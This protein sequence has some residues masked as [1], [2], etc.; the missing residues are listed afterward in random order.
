MSLTYKLVPVQYREYEYSLLANFGNQNDAKL[1]I[2]ARR[3]PLVQE[4]LTEKRPYSGKT[5]QNVIR[6]CKSYQQKTAEKQWK[7]LES[8]LGQ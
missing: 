4:I 6:K 1:K 8:H 5:I 2:L 7:V 3:K